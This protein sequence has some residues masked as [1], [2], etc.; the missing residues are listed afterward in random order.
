[1]LR[2]FKLTIHLWHH[3]FPRTVHFS[4]RYVFIVLPTL[5][6]VQ[7]S[8]FR[9]SQDGIAE[10]SQFIHLRL[11]LF[12][13]PK[14]VFQDLSRASESLL[15]T[16]Q[17]ANSSLHRARLDCGRFFLLQ[18]RHH[19]LPS[20]I[21]LRQKFIHIFLHPIRQFSNRGLHFPEHFDLFLHHP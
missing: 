13:H 20:F 10:S 8:S 7:K 16:L 2:R 14:F 11:K 17:L 6:S 1:M 9:L 19:M 15:Q 5:G 4:H 18:H 3:M 21:V 12:M